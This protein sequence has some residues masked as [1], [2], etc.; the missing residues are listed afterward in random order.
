MPYS[1]PPHFWKK[2]SPHRL[3]PQ[4]QTVFLTLICLFACLNIALADEELPPPTPLIV[5]HK[6]PEL[7]SS[8]RSL[9]EVEV[10]RLALDKTVAEFGPYELRGIPPMNRARTLVSLS[11]N[12]YPNL[13]LQMSY[14]DELP[15]QQNLSYIPFPLDL[16]A[17]SYR[18]CFARNELQ[19]RK[20]PIH[21]LND[22]KNY[23]FGSGIGWS[24]S[25]ILRA[26]GLTVV[27]S[28][29]VLSLFR[30]TKAG[31]VD[32]FCRAPMEMLFEQQFQGNLGLTADKE[33]ALYYP[34][35]KFFFSHKEN[36]ALLT[37]IQK[38]LEIAYADG[39]FKTLWRSRHGEGI[40][41]AQLNQRRIFKLDNPFAQ[42]LPHDYEIYL[43]NPLNP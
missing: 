21:Q 38:G 4:S 6:L 35:P 18:V 29:S 7:G 26:N 40:A 5:T 9:H 14:E 15:A 11:H 31:R 12:L 27:E 32:F 37:R 24:D 23:T 16:G 13:V 39:S 1:N 25:K 17:F 42:D 30:M 28:N 20:K 8:E 34:L 3:L 33:I 19:N 2:H 41:Q 22:L 36:K 43:Y 10:L